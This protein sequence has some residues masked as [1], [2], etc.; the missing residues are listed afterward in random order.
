MN[1]ILQSQMKKE[2]FPE[3]HFRL[4]KNNRIYITVHINVKI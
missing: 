2:A 1:D 4:C 3:I